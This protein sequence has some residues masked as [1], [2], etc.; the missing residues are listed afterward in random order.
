[1]SEEPAKTDSKAPHTGEEAKSVEHATTEP[2]S[3]HGATEASPEHSATEASPEHSAKTASRASRGGDEEMAS[4]S[5]HHAA[6]PDAERAASETGAERG[7]KTTSVERTGSEIRAERDSK[8]LS[9][10]RDASKRRATHGGGKPSAERP[11]AEPEARSRRDLKVEPGAALGAAVAPHLPASADGTVPGGNSGRLI[12]IAAFVTVVVVVVLIGAAMFN[13]A[14]GRV[15]KATGQ[16]AD[17]DP[18]QTAIYRGGRSWHGYGPQLLVCTLGE[19]RSVASPESLP[20]DGLCDLV[21]Y[22]H[23]ES[24]GADFDEGASAN[25]RALWTRA[26]TAVKTRFGYSFSDSLLPVDERQLGPFVRKAVDDKGIKAFGMLDAR[27]DG[28]ASN[29]SYATF[30]AALNSTARQLSKDKRVALVYGVRVDFDTGKRGVEFW[31]W[32]AAILEQAHVLVYQ[33]HFDLPVQNDSAKAQCRVR[34]PSPR[35]KQVKKKDKTMQDG[36]AAIDTALH[37]R[38]PSLTADIC[39]SIALSVHRFSLKRAPSKGEELG[40]KCVSASAVAYGDACANGTGV[41]A[42]GHNLTSID[43]AERTVK[44]TGE[45]VLVNRIE[46]KLLDTF[47]DVET[48]A[49]KLRT[50]K[51]ALSL[52]AQP[53]WSFCLAA[54]N[55]EHADSEGAC[56]GHGFERLT[57]ARSFLHGKLRWHD[58]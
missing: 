51:L 43:V 35:F 9:S 12:E 4:A 42:E 1:M 16:H 29:A 3:D 22:T 7:G 53:H 50:A 48:L 19:R 26:S 49:Q 52:S 14:Y 57:V 28:D 24:L 25:L 37:F 11:K 54:F 23:V 20:P 56:G 34:F 41:V 32:H 18:L 39:L 15:P 40:A 58:D 8:K 38:Q 46:D 21:L 6:K 55:V 30:A 44:I 36:V 47:D 13:S 2:P 27:Q 5:H 33:A 17:D 45:G 10:E 31:H